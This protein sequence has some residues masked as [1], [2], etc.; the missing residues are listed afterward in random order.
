MF[1]FKLKK[2]PHRTHKARVIKLVF[3]KHLMDRHKI[4]IVLIDFF[5][6]SLSILR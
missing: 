2:N 1:F 3:F 5:Y 4:T 6:T